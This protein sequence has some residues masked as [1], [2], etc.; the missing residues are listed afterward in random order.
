LRTEY[1]KQLPAV[2]HVDGSARVRSVQKEEQT[3]FWMLLN[4]FGNISGFP[5]LLNTSFNLRGQPIVCTPWEAVDTFL[6]AQLDALMVGNQLVIA[7][8]SNAG[9]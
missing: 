5:I 1:Q 9:S 8:Q 2:T 6:I 3:R 7:R 4:E